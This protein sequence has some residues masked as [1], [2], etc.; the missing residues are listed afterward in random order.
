MNLFNLISNLTQIP[1]LSSAE[2]CA[3]Q[4]V[5]IPLPDCDVDELKRRLYDEFNIEV[6]VFRW[7]DCCIVRIS[8]QAYN[9]RADASRLIDALS[10]VLK[11]H[12]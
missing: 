7:K 10:D 6:P 9:T 1:L 11:L 4:M 5:A 2:F 3:P 12:A 8:I